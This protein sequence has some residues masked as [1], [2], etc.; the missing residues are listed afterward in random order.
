MKSILSKAVATIGLVSVMASSANAVAGDNEIFIT[1]DV[2][3]T[4]SV[5]FVNVSANTTDAGRFVGH[6]VSLPAIIAG[7]TFAQQSLPV[8][9]LT[10][11]AGG[12]SINISGTAALVDEAAV[13]A[14]IPLTFAFDA[15]A[16]TLGTTVQLVAGTSDGATIEDNFVITPAATPGTQAVGTYSQ[17]LTVTVAAQ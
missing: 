4:V 6:D 13:G 16:Y 1:G 5:G 10:N 3:S 15:G 11:N 14:D 8:Y 7:G 2:S 17:T 9:C 12:V